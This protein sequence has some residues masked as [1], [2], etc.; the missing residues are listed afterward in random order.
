MS[1]GEAWLHER[2][3]EFGDCLLW[4]LGIRKSGAPTANIARRGGASVRNHV[5]VNIYG[6]K[7]RAGFAPFPACG[8]PR[9]LAR[10]CLVQRERGQIVSAG[11]DRLKLMPARL[12][13]FQHQAVIAGHAKLGPTQ[14]AEIRASD[15][16]TREL[17][18]EYGVNRSTICRIRARTSWAPCRAAT[19]IF[20]LGA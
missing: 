2:C 7:L 4:K 14:A 1:F 5:Y 10:D 17:A 13:K 18:A 12:L 16:G 11:C 3:D 8:N 20:N 15:K 19:S 9:C 6:K